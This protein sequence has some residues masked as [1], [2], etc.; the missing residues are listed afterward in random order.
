MRM[1]WSSVRRSMSASECSI[2]PA[3]TASGCS[4]WRRENARSL[5]VSSAPRRDARLAAPSNCCRI[6]VLGQ[7]R[8]VAE[9]L[10]VALDDGE[11]VVEVVGDAA[12]QLADALEPLRV[13]QRLFRLDALQ[14][15]RKQVGERFEEADLVG[16]E[17]ARLAR[18]H[19]EDA[20]RAPEV[21][22]RHGERARQAGVAIAR[23]AR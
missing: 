20:D 1:R 19:D 11:Q 18:A 4:T 6:A 22:E 2:A 12:R 21:R 13:V 5:L 15:A 10:Q 7:A 8:Q 9:N 3:S 16:A 17:V 23:T 14:A